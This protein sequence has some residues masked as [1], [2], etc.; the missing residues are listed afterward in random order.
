MDFYGQW[1]HFPPLGVARFFNVFRNNKIALTFCVEIY[2]YRTDICI[3]LNLFIF[4]Y[5]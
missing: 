5:I 4:Y 3:S 1:R 2:I